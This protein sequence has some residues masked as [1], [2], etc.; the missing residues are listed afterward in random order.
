MDASKLPDQINGLLVPMQ[1][2][3]WLLPASAVAETLDI[4]QPDRPSRGTDWLLGWISWRDQDL[5]LLSFE[6]LNE[7]GQV[8]IGVGA[9]MIVIKSTH[10]IYPFYA[11]IAQG[12]P[13][14]VTVGSDK[15]MQ[16]PTETGPVEAFYAQM[17]ETMV[18]IP[19]LDAID[20]AL[21]SIK[22]L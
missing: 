16:E 2:R 12:E 15:L 22:K 20:K 5:P 3:P 14:T 13:E 7:S 4:R 18:V 11:V 19:D 10:P 21:D 8:K 9:R 6:R 1:A 17:D